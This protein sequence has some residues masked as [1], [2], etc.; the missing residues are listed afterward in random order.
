MTRY[1]WSDLVTKAKIPRCFVKRYAY[2]ALLENELQEK[3]L[4][5]WIIQQIQLQAIQGKA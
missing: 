4:Q 1:D 5:N 3:V 2:G